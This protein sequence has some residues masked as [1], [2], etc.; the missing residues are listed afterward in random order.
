VANSDY[1]RDRSLWFSRFKLPCWWVEKNGFA[2]CWSISGGDVDFIILCGL[3]GMVTFSLS[4]RLEVS[5][6][7]IAMALYKKKTGF[8]YSAPI[9]A[10]DFV[11]IWYRQVIKI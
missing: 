8:G 7:C 9:L 4:S 2:Y 1:G 5:R 6:E 11:G 3:K 10:D